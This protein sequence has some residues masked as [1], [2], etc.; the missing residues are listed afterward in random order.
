MNDPRGLAPEGWHVS[1]KKEWE[2]LIAYLGGGAIASAKLRATSG[3][4]SFTGSKNGTNESG[5]TALPGGY[6]NSLGG[7]FRGKGLEASFWTA[8]EY[9]SSEAWEQ[10]LD[11]Y[12]HDHPIYTSFIYKKFGQSVRCVKD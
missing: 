11:N 3:W 9:N 1:T 4:E 6:L 10:A 2:T 5:F 8:D 7:Y 12:D